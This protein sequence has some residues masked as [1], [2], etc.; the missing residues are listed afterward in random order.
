MIDE[1]YYCHTSTG[2]VHFDPGKGTKHFDAWWA[3][4]ICDEEILK[5]YAWLALKYGVVIQTGSRW[6]SHVSFIKGQKPQR[7]PFWGRRECQKVEFRYS[8]VIRWDNGKHAWLDV[9][10]PELNEIRKE[11]GIPPKDT[12]HL[13]IGRLDVEKD[14]MD[15]KY[16]HKVVSRS[17][18]GWKKF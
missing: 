15:H 5:Y 10:S 13:T 1:T 17:S 12:Y 16:D 6:R 9:Y 11:L 2:W 3:L 14:P 18:K 8:N 4:L 7:M